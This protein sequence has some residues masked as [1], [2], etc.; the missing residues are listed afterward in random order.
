MFTVLI[1]FIV[2]IHKKLL[3][4]IYSATQPNQTEQFLTKRD[5]TGTRLFNKQ[6]YY[7]FSI[8]SS[9]F[10]KIIYNILTRTNQ[11]NEHLT[12]YQGGEM[13]YSEN[14]SPV[15]NSQKNNW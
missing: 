1:S 11:T 6:L 8:M 12:N 4:V 5:L 7:I 3:I 15:K 14:Y 13:F 2:S 9:K 10:T